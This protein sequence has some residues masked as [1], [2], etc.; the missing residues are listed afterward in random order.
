M[1]SKFDGIGDDDGAPAP[2]PVPAPSKD[3]FLKKLAGMQNQSSLP[4]VTD[5]M[6]QMKNLP[7]EAKQKMLEQLAPMADSLKKEKYK[8]RPMPDEGGINLPN[9]ALASDKAAF[10]APKAL[11]QAQEKREEELRLQMVGVDIVVK[12]LVA[13]PELNSRCGKITA[14]NAAKGRYAV[15]LAAL[16]NPILLKPENVCTAGEFISKN[17]DADTGKEGPNWLPPDRVID[18]KTV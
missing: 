11:E 10:A 6:A 17:V 12:G 13:K 1:Y 5:L 8:N 7:P 4:S 9:P 15:S 2:A 14:W 18:G 3:D 16:T